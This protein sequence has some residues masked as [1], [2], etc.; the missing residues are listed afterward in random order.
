MKKYLR[1]TQEFENNYNYINYTELKMY[2]KILLIFVNEHTFKIYIYNFNLKSYVREWDFCIRALLV[3]L[4]ITYLYLLKCEFVE[5]N[6]L[7]LKLFVLCH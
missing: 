6:F 5:K 7:F 3:L 2:K 4:V 1:Y